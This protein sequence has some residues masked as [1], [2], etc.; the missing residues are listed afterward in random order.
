[1]IDEDGVIWG[2]GALDMKGVG[3]LELLSLVWLARLEVPLRR[4]VV[5]LAVGDEEVDNAGMRFLAAQHWAQIGCSH[6]INEGGMGVRDAL[7]EGLDLF[8]VSF[9]EK[10]A[11]WVRMVA[12][13][14]PGHGSTP[15]PD[16]A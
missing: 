4:D 16:S 5:L 10:G 3:V 6:A 7:F 14:E 2:R 9:T 1:V 13:G 8:T 11:L 15:M 12:S